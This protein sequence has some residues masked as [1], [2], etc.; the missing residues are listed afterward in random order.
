[1]R[2]RLP[3]WLVYLL[4]LLV[5]WMAIPSDEGAIAPEAEWPDERAE[6]PADP[7]EAPEAPGVARE[8]QGRPLPAP[9]RFDERALVEAQNAEP[10]STGT[11]FAVGAGGTWLTARH[12]VRGCARLGLTDDD[13]SLAVEAQARFISEDSDV[14]ILSTRG[15]PA[16]LALDLEESDLTLGARSFHVGYPL[17]QAGEVT[18]R[19]IGRE[20]L[21]TEGQWRSVE[22]TLAWAEVGRSRVPKGT[23]GGLSGG[24]VF[25]ESGRV[26]GITIA[27]NPRRGR[28]ITTSAASIVAASQAAGVTARGAPVGGFTPGTYDDVAESLREKRQ[29]VRVVCLPAA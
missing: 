21:F 24:P 19:L 12:V 26:L 11:A 20:R 7:G 14:A 29:V 10:W 18:S 2:L 17:G 28:V 13:M 27:E 15:G 5:I 4:V 9:S 23:L 16:P 1:M 8:G 3:D 6:G 25:D 22:D